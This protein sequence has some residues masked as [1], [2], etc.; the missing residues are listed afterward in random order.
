MEI[1]IPILVVAIV[2]VVFL[3]VRATS[4][5]RS[6]PASPGDLPT[7]LEQKIEVLAGCGFRLAQPFTVED[8]L[9]SWDRAALEKLGYDSVLVAMGMTEEQEPWR[10]H[11]VNLWTFDTE[12][13]EDHG[14]YKKIA[15]RMAEL[16]GG[17]LPIE[18]IRDYVD[19]EN[20]EA[21][22]AFSFHGKDIKIECEVKDD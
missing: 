13:I 21:W 22:L 9:Q 6:N 10:N 14:A 12:C 8:L 5:P 1:L 16:A 4:H 3:L 7:T 17:S 20:N 11:C 2:V 19:V 15:E 18:N